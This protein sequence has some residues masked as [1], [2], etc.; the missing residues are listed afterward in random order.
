MWGCDTPHSRIHGPKTGS[1]PVGKVK[2]WRKKRKGER[3]IGKRKKEKKREKK[4]ERRGERKER[5]RKGKT[6]QKSS[7]VSVYVRGGGIGKYVGC[8]NML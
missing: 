8:N 3:K 4:M 2:D 5:M 7:F 1:A 6:K